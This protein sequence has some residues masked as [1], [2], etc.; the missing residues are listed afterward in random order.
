MRRRACKSNS[1][2]TSALPTLSPTFEGGP[3][4]WS[5]LS[6]SFNHWLLQRDP[7]N[8]PMIY[9]SRTNHLLD[10]A[11]NGG[12]H[13]KVDNSG[14]IVGTEPVKNELSH[15]GDGWA[16]S[17]Y[18]LLGK[19]EIQINRGKLKQQAIKLRKRAEGYG[20]GRQVARGFV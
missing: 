17:V 2:G 11:L 12:W 3:V 10:K 9:I 5:E 14:N 16:N 18:V 13:Y 6:N 8:Q 20:A 1:T 19:K 4:K 7:D 15:I